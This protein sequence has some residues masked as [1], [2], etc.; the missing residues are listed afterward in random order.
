[1]TKTFKIGEY[2]SGGT[3]KVLIP[4][5]LTTIKIQVLDTNSR[6]FDRSKE[7]PELVGEYIY[8]SF[9]KNRIERDLFGI[10]T[11]Y[12]AEKI[13]DYIATTMQ[14]EPKKKNVDY[15][16]MIGSRCSL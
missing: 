15:A 9:D 12:W 13:T 8:Y 4:K 5:T 2:A 10:T 7:E 6:A 16:P 14:I 1:M 11:C 3:I